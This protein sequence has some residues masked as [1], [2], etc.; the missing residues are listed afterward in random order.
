M[1]DEIHRDSL[2]AWRA[3]RDTGGM[4]VDDRDE[5]LIAQL[6]D[7][8]DPAAPDLESALASTSMD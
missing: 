6:K 2:S 3:L 4:D 8:L 5:D 7:R 1:A